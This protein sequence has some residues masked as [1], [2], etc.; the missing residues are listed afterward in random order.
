[1][2]LDELDST[3]VNVFDFYTTLDLH[4]LLILKQN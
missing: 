1:M 2:R 4:G 3:L